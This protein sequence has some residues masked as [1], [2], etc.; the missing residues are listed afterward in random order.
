MATDLT[1]LEKGKQLSHQ[2]WWLSICCLFLFS[3][4]TFFL[5]IPLLS[6]YYLNQ[7]DKGPVVMVSGVL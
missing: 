6:F 7:A 1:D 2:F 5:L 4:F 3:H